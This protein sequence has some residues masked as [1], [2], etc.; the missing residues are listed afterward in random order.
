MIYS[1]VIYSRVLRLFPE[2]HG[3]IWLSWS[4]FLLALEKPAYICYETADRGLMHCV[5]YCTYLRKDGQAE[6]SRAAG[7]TPRWFTCP[8][9]VTMPV[10]TDPSIE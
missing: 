9:S 8:Q 1:R 4:L 6:L 7:Y 3:S 10:F 2:P 5:V